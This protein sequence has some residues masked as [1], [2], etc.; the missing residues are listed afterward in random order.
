MV[1]S[2]AAKEKI[3]VT[4]SR[5]LLAYA[6]KKAAEARISRSRVIAE[7][8]EE[9]KAREELELAAEGYRFYSKESDEFASSSLLAFSEALADAD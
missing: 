7:A 4:L 1:S 2:I 6:E 3:T 8:L 5:D 9:K